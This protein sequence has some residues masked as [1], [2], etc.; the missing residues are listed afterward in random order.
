MKV[1]GVVWSRTT[2]QTWGVK[3][4]LFLNFSIRGAASAAL[5]WLGNISH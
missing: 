5:D 2:S 3:G 1:S 4:Y